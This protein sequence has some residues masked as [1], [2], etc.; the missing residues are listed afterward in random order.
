M[1]KLLSLVGKHYR[2]IFKTGTMYIA[3]DTI[4]SIIGIFTPL[5]KTISPFS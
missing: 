1:S 2:N 3:I 5:W 4:Y